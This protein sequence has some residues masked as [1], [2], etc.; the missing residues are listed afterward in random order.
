MR[1]SGLRRVSNVR[2]RNMP[3][4]CARIASPQS[5]G[6]RSGTSVPGRIAL[7]SARNDVSWSRFGHPAAGVVSS[8]HMVKEGYYFGV[9]PLLLGGLA[10]VF[11]WWISAQCSS[12]LLCSVFLFF[13]I[14]SGKFQ[15]SRRH[16][17]ARR[18]TS[19]G[20]H[21]RGKRRPPRHAHQYFSGDL[22]RSR[23]SF[24]R[25]GRNLQDSITAR[26]NSWRLGIPT[27]RPKTS[28]IYLRLAPLTE[29]SS[30]SRSPA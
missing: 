16:R 6:N 2:A 22:E 8:Y 29:I 26:E 7:P 13:A 23:K 21:R 4:R 12:P 27:P 15:R 20:R 19:C 9:P 11:H 18:W 1:W 28:K 10:I 30:S 25:R 14:R 17:F 5:A 24:A 3:S